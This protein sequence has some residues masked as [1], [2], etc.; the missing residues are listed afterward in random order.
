VTASGASASV[1]PTKPRKHLIPRPPPPS[2]EEVAAQ[3]EFRARQHA[4]FV[5]YQERRKPLSAKT[6]EGKLVALWPKWIDQANT[7]FGR[8]TFL[9]CRCWR[10]EGDRAVGPKEVTFWNQQLVVLPRH[11]WSIGRIRLRGPSYAFEP[12]SEKETRKVKTL[13]PENGA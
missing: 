3:E 6:L 12:A 2:P 10:I 9:S 7:K 4:S 11:A 1:A 13:L 8:K 5:E